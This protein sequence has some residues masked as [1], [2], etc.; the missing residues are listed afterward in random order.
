MSLTPQHC[1]LPV[2]VAKR[3]DAQVAAQNFS[4]TLTATAGSVGEHRLR[5]ASPAL[6]AESVTAAKVHRMVELVDY[7]QVV[8]LVGG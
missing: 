3:S 8:Q 1:D 5:M 2:L 6:M 4:Q 7:F